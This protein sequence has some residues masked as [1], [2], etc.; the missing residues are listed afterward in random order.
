MKE[1]AV[2]KLSHPSFEK[3]ERV[4]SYLSAFFFFGP[5][6]GTVL[7]WEGICGGMPIVSFFTAFH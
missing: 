6:Y 5:Y 3:M 1:C 7:M 2:V 4:A